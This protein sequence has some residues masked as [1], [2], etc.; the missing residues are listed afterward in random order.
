MHFLVLSKKFLSNTL[1]LPSF[2]NG[3]TFSHTR[4]SPFFQRLTFPLY[5]FFSHLFLSIFHLKPLFFTLFLP[6]FTPFFTQ[7]SAFLY[8]HFSLSS[9]CTFLPLNKQHLHFLVLSIDFL[10]NTLV[11]PYYLLIPFNKLSISLHLALLFSLFPPIFYFLFS[12]LCIIVVIIC[13]MRLFTP[14]KH[15]FKQVFHNNKA[16]D[17]KKPIS[18]LFYIRGT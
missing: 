4:H 14:Q 13:Y 15:T 2:S 8:T 12:G 5:S 17:F 1:I 9:P 6:P 10:S 18:A 7:N 11:T 3:L 16:K